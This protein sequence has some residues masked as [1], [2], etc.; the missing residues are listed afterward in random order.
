MEDGGGDGG[1]MTRRDREHN[2]TK[3][4]LHQTMRRN[5]RNNS[6]PKKKIKEDL[7]NSR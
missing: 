3:K 7:L 5:G 1:N 6:Q 4:P 2:K